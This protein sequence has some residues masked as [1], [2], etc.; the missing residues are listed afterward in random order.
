MLEGISIET[1]IQMAERT[2]RKQN[3]TLM[4]V[5]TFHDVKKFIT[6]VTLM[7]TVEIALSKP[8]LLNYI[9]NKCKKTTKFRCE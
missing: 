2:W 5:I 7:E 1:N 9:A 4:R 6:N 3:W 8:F